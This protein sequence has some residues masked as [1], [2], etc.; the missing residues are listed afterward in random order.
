MNV[1]VVLVG[2]HGEANQEQQK[3]FNVHG[4]NKTLLLLLPLVITRLLQ[5]IT[6]I[7]ESFIRFPQ[8]GY[9]DI[10]TPLLSYLNF[11]LRYC[12]TQLSRNNTIPSSYYISSSTMSLPTMGMPIRHAT[13]STV[14]FISPTGKWKMLVSVCHLS[15]KAVMMPWLRFSYPVLVPSLKEGA[16]PNAFTRSQNHACSSPKTV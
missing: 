13:S 10:P 9:P 16:R 2:E 12:K 4:P 5:L 15:D 11:G 3:C 6:H 8:V 14:K 7:E 1:Y